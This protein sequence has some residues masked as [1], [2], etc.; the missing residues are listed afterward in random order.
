MLQQPA[1]HWG[2]Q[3]GSTRQPHTQDLSGTATWYVLT[4]F[5]LDA[6][7]TPR[8][9][10]LHGSAKSVRAVTGLCQHRSAADIL[11]NTIV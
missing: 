2:Q 4:A 7:C 9:E 10:A 11:L 6:L 3:T 5:A 8:A 1:S